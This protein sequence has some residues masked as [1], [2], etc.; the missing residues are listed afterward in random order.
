MSKKQSVGPAPTKIISGD[1]IYSSEE[2]KAKH[3][4]KT[5][6][7]VV[8]API[9]TD[10]IAAQY[11]LT[12]ATTFS[13]EKA[14]H[15]R[16]LVLA[17]VPEDHSLRIAAVSVTGDVEN[18][19]PR[20][21]N[22]LMSD[23]YLTGWILYNLQAYIAYIPVEDLAKKQ[24]EFIKGQDGIEQ[25]SM[26]NKMLNYELTMTEI[27]PGIEE[28]KVTAVQDLYEDLKSMAAG[29]GAVFAMQGDLQNT[30]LCMEYAGAISALNNRKEL[31]PIII[32]MTLL[33]AQQEAANMNSFSAAG[34]MAGL[35]ALKKGA[36][37]DEAAK[38][39]DET[40]ERLED[41]AGIQDL[42]A[43]M[44]EEIRKGNGNPKAEA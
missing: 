18:D 41:E 33:H 39:S 26:G 14:K 16:S 13:R 28:Y 44:E 12:F 36:S 40:Q 29:A 21:D 30:H 4:D 9:Q 43:K 34:L 35:K 23:S 19:R 10:E 32:M 2:F 8:V 15:D 42:A 25:R 20:L 3:P 24:D 38:I 1:K 17:A 5:L 7:A 31:S 11:D 27:F 37:P 22:L 6:A